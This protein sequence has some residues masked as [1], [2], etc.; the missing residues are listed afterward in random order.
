MGIPLTQK[1][2]DEEAHSKFIFVSIDIT[3][4]ALDA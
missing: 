4:I 2:K 3:C 1:P